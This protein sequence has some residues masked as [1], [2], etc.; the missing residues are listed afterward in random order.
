MHNDAFCKMSC[1]NFG[2]I[3]NFYYA[4]ICAIG[5]YVNFKCETNA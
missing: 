5:A 3:V 4:S 1:N 2:N